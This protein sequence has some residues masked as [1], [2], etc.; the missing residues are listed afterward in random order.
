MV[1]YEDRSKLMHGS[2]S[3]IPEFQVVAETEVEN[4]VVR[5]SE[6][7]LKESG[8]PRLNFNPGS[9][10]MLTENR[11]ET[12]IP[13]PLDPLTLGGGTISTDPSN[14][15]VRNSSLTSSKGT[16][17]PNQES[18]RTA[19]AATPTPTIQKMG[20]KVGP[21][22]PQIKDKNNEEIF[23][24]LPSYAEPFSRKIR[25]IILAEKQ[26]L[27]KHKK[28]N[29]IFSNVKIR[30]AYTNNKNIKKLVVRTKI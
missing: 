17:F 24:V 8:Y 18:R 23:L 14:I 13:V 28:Y 3:T 25:Q 12:N 20:T 15:I 26:K 2:L 19:A 7:I 9:N 21:K 6:R 11:P 29:A 27:C 1:Q 22:V 5:D 10:E 30:L 16:S 4:L